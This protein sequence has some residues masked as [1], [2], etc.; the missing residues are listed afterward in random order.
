M[1]RIRRFLVFYFTRC[2]PYF[3]RVL[4]LLNLICCVAHR[5]ELV[6]MVGLVWLI[7]D[8]LRGYSKEVN[9]KLTWSILFNFHHTKQYLTATWHH[10]INSMKHIVGSKLC[11]ST[12]LYS[13]GTLGRRQKTCK[14]V[15]QARLCTYHIV[16]NHLSLVCLWRCREHVVSVNIS[17]NTAHR[18]RVCLWGDVERLGTIYCATPWT[19][20]LLLPSA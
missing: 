15:T 17:S 7:V 16:N 11:T 19:C 9:F 20:Q 18:A 1:N 10:I 14:E 13:I 8:K 5:R 2:H 3:L 4:A 6:L 12:A